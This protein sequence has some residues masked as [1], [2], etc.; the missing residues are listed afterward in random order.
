MGVFAKNKLI[1]ICGF[2]AVV[3]GENPFQG[4]NSGGFSQ[5][6]YK[7]GRNLSFE[8][9]KKQVSMVEFPAHFRFF[10]LEAGL[11]HTTK[12]FITNCVFVNSPPR[13]PCDGV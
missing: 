9:I 10:I 2:K 5:D 6:Y 8:S 3:S 1:R 13:P 11:Q 7:K 12:H 4:I